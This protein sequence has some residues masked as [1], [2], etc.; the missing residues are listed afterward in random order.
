[1]ADE[2]SRAAVSAARPSDRA[3][4]DGV[5]WAGV[6]GAVIIGLAVAIGALG[7]HYLSGRIPMAREGTFDTAVRYQFV[8]GF[9][10]VLLAA[11]SRGRAPRLLP[12][13]QRAALSLASGALLF[14]GSLYLLVAGGPSVLGAVA[15]LGGAAMILGW[16][17]LALALRRT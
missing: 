15:P 8:S 2:S 16:A 3:A 13:F 14:C 1:M 17:L 11:L 10:L 4:T 6:W 7:T 12:A 5:V 9:G